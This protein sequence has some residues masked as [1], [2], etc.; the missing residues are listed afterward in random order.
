MMFQSCFSLLNIYAGTRA[1]TTRIDPA[2][3]VLQRYSI[4]QSIF[5]RKQKDLVQGLGHEP[6]FQ[7]VLKTSVRNAEVVN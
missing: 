7:K 3:R 4:S 2:Q 5:T 1:H 6:S